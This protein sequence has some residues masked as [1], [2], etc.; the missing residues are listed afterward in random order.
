[1]VKDCVLKEE[2][3]RIETERERERREEGK[4]KEGG[5]RVPAKP[6]VVNNITA[7]SGR[8][9]FSFFFFFICIHLLLLLTEETP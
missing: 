8:S 9:I 6:D 5:W 7:P 3:R 1:M 4:K 2:R